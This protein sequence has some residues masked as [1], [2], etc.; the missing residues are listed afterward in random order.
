[1]Y[2]MAKESIKHLPRIVKVAKIRNEVKAVTTRF[3]NL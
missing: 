1:M 2:V 3:E